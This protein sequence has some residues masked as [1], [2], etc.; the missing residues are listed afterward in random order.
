[1]RSDQCGAY[2]DKLSSETRKHLVSPLHGSEIHGVES[3]G[4]CF[5]HLSLTI[6]NFQELNKVYVR[7]LCV[8]L[9]PCVPVHA[10]VLPAVQ[11]CA[12]SLQIW[13]CGMHSQKGVTACRKYS[14]M[15]CKENFCS[16]HLL[17]HD[18]TQVVITLYVPKIL[19]R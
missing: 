8:I 11:Q 10:A 15:C 9:L 19:D 14:K 5:L 13:Q 12:F 7:T 2:R 18:L 17:T 3:L 16:V 4:P 6:C 1:M